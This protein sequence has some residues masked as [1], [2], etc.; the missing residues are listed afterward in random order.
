MKTACLVTAL[1]FCG[2]AACDKP[3]TP[4]APKTESKV[5]APATTAGGSTTTTTTTTTPAQK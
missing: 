3:A 2:V 1:L 5:Q 4:P